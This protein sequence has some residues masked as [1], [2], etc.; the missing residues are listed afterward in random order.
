MREL[1]LHIP[2]VEPVAFSATHRPH[3]TALDSLRGLAA[4]SMAFFHMNWTSPLYGLAYVR[5]SYLMVDVFFVLSGF[6]IFYAYQGKIGSLKEARRF[7]W[8]RFW[9]VYPVHFLFLIVFGLIEVAKFFA[10]LHYGLV[11]NHPALEDN[12]LRSFLANL[13]LVQGLNPTRALSFNG[14]SWTISVEFAA[15]ILFAG[16][17]LVVRSPAAIVKVSL[18]ISVAAIA[19][20]AWLG[21]GQVAFTNIFG[22]VPCT[23]GFFLGVVVCALAAYL[24]NSVHVAAHTGLVTGMA[25]ATIGLFMAFLAIRHTGYMPIAVFPLSAGMIFLVA[26]APA[27]GVLRFLHLGPLRWLGAISYSVYMAQE[28]AIWL[29]KA[30]LRF[31]THARDIPVPGHQPVLAVISPIGTVAAAFTVLLVLGIAQLTY[32]LVEMPWRDWS[33]SYALRDSLYR[34]ISDAGKRE[35]TE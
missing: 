26:L 28:A 17:F 20:L 7:L 31:A 19:L 2:A 4:L 21:K 3:H 27:A 23:A 12:N 16:L 13:F 33:R 10:Q 30:L 29:V 5:N 1:E 24:R 25:A 14:P 9:R 35:P 34:Q 8:L 11:A 6:V 18:A 15:Y 32:N 22:I